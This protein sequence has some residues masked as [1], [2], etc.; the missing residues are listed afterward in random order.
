[1]NLV[2]GLTNALDLIEFA[3]GDETTVLGKE[4]CRY[5]SSK[6]IWITLSG[7]LEMRRL[8]EGFTERYPYFHKAI[9]GKIS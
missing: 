2:L 5:G 6:A 3:N 9:R 4:A 8:D 7:N 1:M